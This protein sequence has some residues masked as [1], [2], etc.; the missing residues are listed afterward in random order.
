MVWVAGRIY[1]TGRP[2]DYTKVHALQDKFSV[3]PLSSYGQ[4]YTPL[5]NTAD[6]SWTP[7]ALTSSLTI[8]P[9]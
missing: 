8:L 3:V 6:A 4:P 5:P 7:W 2:D 1:C 9:G